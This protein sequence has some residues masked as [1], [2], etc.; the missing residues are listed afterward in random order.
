VPNFDAAETPARRA[1]R[2]LFALGFQIAGRR[3]IDYAV[4]LRTPPEPGTDTS[5]DA[6]IRRAMTAIEAGPV[7][8]VAENP[9]LRDEPLQVE[10]VDARGGAVAAGFA[11]SR[12]AANASYATSSRR[13]FDIAPPSG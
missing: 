12:S 11:T 8:F 13:R 2:V 4:R 6:R 3:A 1:K 10:E 7:A 5:T 9:E